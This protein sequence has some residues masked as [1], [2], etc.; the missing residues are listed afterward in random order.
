[1]RILLDECLP[2]RLARELIGHE[3]ETVPQA[4]WSGI[5]NGDLLHRAADRFDALLTIDQRFAQGV[6]VP[7]SLVLV[8]IAAKSN[9][10]ESLKPLIPAILQALVKT[11]KGERG[12]V[13]G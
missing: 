2:R 12:R 4:G 13:G 3:V 1:M 9:R 6:S 7:P 11:P 8:T 10:F 5:K